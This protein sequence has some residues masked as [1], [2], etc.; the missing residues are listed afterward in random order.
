MATFTTGTSLILELENLLKNADDTLI[1]VSPFINLHQRYKDVLIN[2]KS[3]DKLKISILFGKNE[4]DLTKSFNKSD[5]D[6]FKQFPNIQIRYNQNLHAKFYSNHETSIT[7]SMNL[8]TYSQDNNIETGVVTTNSTLKNATSFVA[9]LHNLDLEQYKFFNELITNSKLLFSN[10]P[11][12][13]GSFLTSKFDSI[14]ND[15]DLL[16]E[17]YNKQLPKSDTKYL[18]ITALSKQIEIDSKLLLS[19][20][21]SLKFIEKID[22]S[23]KPTKI[24]LSKGLQLKNG[25]YGEYIHYP[26]SIKEHL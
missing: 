12:Y 11:V 8:F 1:L 13:K 15:I 7:T 16:S 6:F 21:E 5:F 24:G 10:S 4:N 22:K 18:T 25:T 20:F 3:N 19:K 9:D 17:I 26:E 14:K 23:Y 2:H